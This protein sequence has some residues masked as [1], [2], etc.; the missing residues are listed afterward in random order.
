MVRNTLTTTAATFTATAALLLTACGGG[1]GDSSQDDINGT[2]TG[3]ARPSASESPSPSTRPGIDRPVIKLP[4][5]F[6]LTFEDWK[7]SDAKQQAVLDDAREELRAGYA[8][9]TADDPDSESVAFYDTGSSRSQ[10]KKWIKSYT[11]KSVTVVGK[12]PVFDP[13]VTLLDDG[14]TASLGYCTDESEAYTKHRKTGETEG[15]PE[16]MDPHVYYQ[17]TLRK[18]SQGVW[19]NDTV[20]SERG[21]CAK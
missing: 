8:A 19:Q 15:N 17:V 5:S 10:S 11:D 14:S 18:S 3:A 2:E 6:Q 12:L 4:S 9:I 16:Y 7:S 1:S 21:G 20:H 13:K